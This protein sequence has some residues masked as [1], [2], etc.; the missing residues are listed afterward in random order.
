MST[1][2]WILFFIA[3][4]CFTS[5][6]NNS[7]ESS[8]T[9]RD[10]SEQ[11]NPRDRRMPSTGGTGSENV[12]TQQLNMLISES[13]KT[14]D[15]IEVAYKN[16]AA[17]RTN[18]SMSMYEREEVNEALMELND[19]KDLIILETQEAVIAELKEKTSSLKSVMQKM[20]TASSKMQ[21]VARCLSKVSGIIEQTTN[22]LASA[23]TYGIIRPRIV[24]GT[25]TQT[26]SKS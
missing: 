12:K 1:K 5:C 24:A 10:S 11:I 4:I 19:A 6:Q 25:T 22:I 8:T 15:S 21:N 13:K 14:L 18:R 26:V 20:N 2:L 23:L 3:L 7:Q 17:E 9:A 16:I